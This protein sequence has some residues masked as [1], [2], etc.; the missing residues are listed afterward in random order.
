MRYYALLLFSILFIFATKPCVAVYEGTANAN[1]FIRLYEQN[2]DYGRLALWHET[3]AECLN[4]ISVPMNKIT[5]NYYKSNG[6]EKWTERAVKEALEIQEQIQF[7]L[8]QAKSAWKKSKTTENFLNKERE[9]I[10]KYMNTWLPHY[11]DRFYT[12]G[13]YATFFKEQQER[14]ELR[15]DYAKV[16][17]LEADAAEMCAAQY[18]KIPIANGLDNYTELRDKYLRHATLLRTLA[19][20]TLKKLPKDISIG[21]D[22]Q[23]QKPIIQNLPQRSE[24]NILHIATSNQRIINLISAHKVVREYAW[25]QGFAW[26]VS[27]YNHS[28]GNLAIAIID[29]KTGKIIDILEGEHKTDQYEYLD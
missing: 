4:L 27:F 19:K 28:W 1:I 23:D 14:A 2:G 11:P 22:I 3:A 16:L 26:T 25:F 10:A 17:K 24:N 13:I 18:D 8:K 20:P 7:H 6:Y 21:N 15:K 9:K 5:L 29:D 12:F